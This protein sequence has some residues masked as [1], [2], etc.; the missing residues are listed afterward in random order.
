V[1]LHCFAGGFFSTLA[2]VLVELNG[3]ENIAK[4]MAILNLAIGTGCLLATPFS[5]ILLA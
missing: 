2:T 4:S 1:I 3:I 5:G